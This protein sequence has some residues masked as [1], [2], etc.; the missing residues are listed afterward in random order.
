MTRE[1]HVA[2]PGGRRGEPPVQGRVRDGAEHGRADRTADRPEEQVGAGHHAPAVPADDRLHRDEVRAGRQAEPD[3]DDEARDREDRQ[4]RV[5][6][7]QRAHDRA[8]D[9][10]HPTDEG[11]VAEPDAQV[12]LP[13]RGR[14]QG[15]AQRHRRHHEPGE[16]GAGA[17]HALREVRHV[18]RQPDQQRPHDQRHQVA[19]D[20]RTVPEHPQRQHRLLRAALHEPERD[21]QHRTHR[22]DRHA[23]RRRPRPG[24]AAL[25]GAEDQQR[26]PGHQQR[27]AEVVDAVHAPL[28]A[29]LQ[30]PGQHPRRDQPQRD[31]HEEDPPPRQVVG[32]HPAERRAHHRRHAPHP[33]HVPLHPGPFLDRVQVTDDRHAHR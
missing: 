24:R 28:D 14:R 29:L 9:D 21:H 3:T 12:D 7:E 18:G 23:R 20:E 5:P 31:V 16:H 15:P 30:V 4:R 27:R 13:G 1:H 10:D 32:E 11:R 26:A 33:G 19:A 8:C 22:E 17:Q 25:Q 2:P 6:A